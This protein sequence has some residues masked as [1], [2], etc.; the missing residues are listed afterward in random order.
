MKI[1]E[2]LLNGNSFSALL[3]QLSLDVEDINIKDE[4]LIMFGLTMQHQETMKENICIEGKNQDGA[5]NLIGTL[6]YNMLYQLAVF[7]MQGYEKVKLVN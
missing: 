6:H 3:K 2:L 1:K 7:E 5:V 4:E